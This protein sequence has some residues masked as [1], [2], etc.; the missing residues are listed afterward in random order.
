MMNL[1][2]AQKIPLKKD[3]TKEGIESNPGPEYVPLHQHVDSGSGK[4]TLDSSEA[5]LEPS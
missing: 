2:H 4:V 5:L 3:L 1:F